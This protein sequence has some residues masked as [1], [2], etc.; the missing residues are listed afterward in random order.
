MTGM[1]DGFLALLGFGLTFPK[2]PVVGLSIGV[3]GLVLPTGC[4]GGLLYGGLPPMDRSVVTLT[5]D[6]GLRPSSGLPK[7]GRDG[8]GRDVGGSRLSFR[9]GN[10]R[11]VGGGGGGRRVGRLLG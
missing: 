5:T 9:S 7:K 1:G 2:G 10:G 3:Y 6:P 4:R 11:R 8:R